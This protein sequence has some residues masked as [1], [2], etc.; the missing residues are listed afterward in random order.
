MKVV[1]KSR[2]ADNG[3][4]SM[5]ELRAKREPPV[6]FKETCFKGLGAVM[7]DDVARSL[8]SVKQRQKEPYV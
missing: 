6:V 4:Q 7:K 5:A 3:L 2:I 1:V 8:R